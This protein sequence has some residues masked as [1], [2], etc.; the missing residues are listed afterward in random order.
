MK[1]I[2]MIQARVGSSRLRSKVL[3]E[4][5]G[6]PVLRRVIERV[7]KSELVDEVIVITSVEKDNLPLLS[8]C[9]SLDTRVFVGSENDVLD[10]YYQAS[11]V[12]DSDY[13]IRI[14]ADCPLFDGGL[15]DK[16]IKSMSP[17]DDYLGMISE[18]FADG[19]DLE[20]FKTEALRKSWKEAR[21]QSEREHVTQYIRKHPEMFVLKDFVS[22]VGDFGENRWTLDEKE[23][24]ELI[25]NIIEH[26]EN[27]GINDYSYKDI[28]DYV[29]SHPEVKAINAKFSRNEGLQK[30]LANDTIVNF[31]ED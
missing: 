7:R 15:L 20:I 5:C 9:A 24:F 16:A 6:K 28:L 12:Y 4:I 22:P 17:E 14:T 29:N 2:A 13:I 19:L 26:F 11:R 1:Y 21:L 18:T 3:M 31:L 8:L 25:K 10:R 30:S 27:N 23:D